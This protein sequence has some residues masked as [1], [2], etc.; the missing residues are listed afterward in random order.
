MNMTNIEKAIRHLIQ[1]KSSDIYE[2]AGGEGK[3]YL[4]YTNGMGPELSRD[5]VRKMLKASMIEHKYND[6]TEC[7]ILK[8]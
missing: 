5:E 6:K 4:S 1:N 3:Y 8:K 7:Y 2:A